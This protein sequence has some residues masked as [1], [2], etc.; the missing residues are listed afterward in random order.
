[1][2]T[3][4]RIIEAPQEEESKDSLFQEFQT[5]CTELF[6]S[7][8]KKIDEVLVHSIIPDFPSWESVENIVKIK[9][10]RDSIR[11]STPEEKKALKQLK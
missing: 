11:K 8:T 3:I 5:L 4:N 9:E 2:S 7:S 10:V 6:V 1:M